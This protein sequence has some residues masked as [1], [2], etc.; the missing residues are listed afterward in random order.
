MAM[1]H[2]VVLVRNQ[3]STMV[4]GN[5]VDKMV[6]VVRILKVATYLTKKVEK[7]IEENYVENQQ[8]AW[9]VL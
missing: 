3:N 9:V 8:E 1:S 5:E 4:V 6:V 7:E 2:Q